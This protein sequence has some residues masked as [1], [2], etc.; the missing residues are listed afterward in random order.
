MLHHMLR[1]AGICLTAA[2]AAIAATNIRAEQK[3]GLVLSGG[4]ARGIAHVGLIQALEDNDIPIDYIAGTSMGAI[5]SGLYAIGYSPAE[6]MELFNSE[7]FQYWSSGNIDPENR[8]YF[9][10][11]AASPSMG[12]FPVG[13]DSV[14]SRVPQSVVSPNAMNFP[15]MRLFAGATARCHE[16]FDNLF[17]PLRTVSSNLKA[18]RGEVARSG[19]LEQAIRAS[20]SFPIMFA[21]VMINDTLHYD[22]GIFNNFPVDVMRSEFHPDIMIGGDVHTATPNETPTFINQV[23]NLATR[24]Q[25]YDLPADE[26]IKIPMDVNK[27]AL[28][29]FAVGNAIYKV[30]YDKGMAMADSI[31]KRVTA[32][33]SKA[34]VERRRREF[35]KSIPQPEFTEIICTGGTPAQNQYI[36]SQFQPTGRPMSMAKARNGYYRAISSGQLADLRL[37]AVP[38]DSNLFQLEMTA[39]PRS[40]WSVDVGAYM[41]SGT[42][43]M[44]YG[45]LNYNTL[46]TR[47]VNAAG[48]VWF[49]Q[50]YLAAQVNATIRFG[51][52]NPYSLGLEGVVSR[53]VY[54]ETDKLFFQIHNASYD[55]DFEAFGRANLISAALGRH[56]QAHFQA[57]YGYLRNSV[58]AVSEQSRHIDHHLWQLALRY[59]FN[60]LDGINYPTTGSAAH[61]SGM[62]LYGRHGD[63][64]V[65]LNAEAQKY[66]S[67][68]RKLSL[69]AHGQLLAS[70][71]KTPEDPALALADA[72]A[73]MP[74]PS[75]FTAVNPSFRA[76]KFLG[77]GAVPIWKLTNMLQL[78]GNF[79]IF[80]PYER[81][82]SAKKLD[83]VEFMGQVAAVASI[84]K[85][86]VA[87]FADYRTGRHGRGGWFGGIAIG[88]FM[89][90]PSFLK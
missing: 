87:A 39:F 44:L 77:A 19:S 38:V 88:I 17:V 37:N 43:S 33:R 86:D 24:P 28:F 34:E 64:W 8:F 49:G 66:W 50:N 25:T 67:L 56:A 2:A 72:P 89:P 59:D 11:P 57:G 30:G 41:T 62:W 47:A 80:L 6:M 65:Q 36:V 42:S 18:Q 23:T 14:A 60:T 51:G 46:N 52:K 76:Y 26:G 55:I 84:K 16:N 71:R 1:R 27:F 61:I 32:R 10:T 4:G 78:R 69:G 5:V 13:N 9:T 48:A 35:K 81:I 75:C 68:S 7:G 83:T 74:T 40:P 53:H 45:A 73:Y 79:N 22:G 90:A 12:R 3:V 54:N 15:F 63:R 85:I 82:G 70:T 20:M 31:R 58:H 21:P 29:D